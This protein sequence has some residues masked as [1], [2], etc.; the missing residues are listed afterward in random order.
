[1]FDGETIVVNLHGALIA[2]SMRLTIG[3]NITI[4]VYI[5]D[6]RAAGRVVYIDPDN[7]LHCGIELDEPRNIWGVA[8]PRNDWHEKVTSET[9]PHSPVTAE[10][11]S[12]AARKK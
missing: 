6:K 1:M 11:E 8:L 5:T 3:I 12:K 4:H 7:P 2:T 10:R 9:G